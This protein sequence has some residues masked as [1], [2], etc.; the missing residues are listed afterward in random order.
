[1]TDLGN[2]TTH[3]F[4]NKRERILLL[5]LLTLVPFVLPLCIVL[6]KGGTLAK[7]ELF[8]VGLIL[9]SLA[10]M[11]WGEL[12][13][14]DF[15]TAHYYISQ[16]GIAVSTDHN[17][18]LQIRDWKQLVEVLPHQLAFLDGS[19]IVISMLYPFRPK[20]YSEMRQKGGDSFEKARARG[21]ERWWL[22]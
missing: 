12:R 22:M 10:G 3:F 4:L 20:L 9:G 21:E 15:L 1:V 17:V 2:E 19:K 16:Y 6:V 11:L 13:R 18:P 8:T 5:S 14:C 7:D